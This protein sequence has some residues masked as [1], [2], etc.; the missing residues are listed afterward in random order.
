[1][2]I[3]AKILDIE[4]KLSE[5][6]QIDYFILLRRPAI[7]WSNPPQMAMIYNDNSHPIQTNMN[8][9]ANMLDIE[10]KFSEFDQMGYL[11]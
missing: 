11:N 6:D 3:S 10:L 8:N 7:T 4:Q 2:N 1:M 9:S 5:C